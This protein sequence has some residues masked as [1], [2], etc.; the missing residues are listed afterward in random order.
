MALV[1]PTVD[2]HISQS[3]FDPLAVQRGGETYR[4]GVG[5]VE[6]PP[7]RSTARAAD[8][9]IVCILVYDTE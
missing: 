8:A 6:H 3:A 2:H 4:A 5:R 9:Y 1:M 7:A